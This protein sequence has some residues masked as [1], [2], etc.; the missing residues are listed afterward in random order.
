MPPA[1]PLTDSLDCVQVQYLQ[2]LR[3]L[4]RPLEPIRP[5]YLG[6]VEQGA[7]NARDG[8]LLV[9]RSILRSKLTTVHIDTGPGATG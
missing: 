7:G 2:P 3:L 5:D 4:E 1:T 9:D 6:K 8:N